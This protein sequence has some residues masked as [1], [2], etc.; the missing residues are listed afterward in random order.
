M[1]RKSAVKYSILSIF[2]LSLL[3]VLTYSSIVKAPSNGWIKEGN[4]VYVDDSNVYISAN[5]HTLHSSGWVYLNLTSKNYNGDI[6]IVFGFD[7]TQ[8]KPKKMLLYHPHDV[9]W[10]TT[11][12][13]TFY[14]VSNFVTT[15]DPCDYGHEY[16]SIKRDVT[17]TTPSYDNSTNTT[18]WNLVNS[19]VCFDSYEDLGNNNY[20]VTWHNE[21]S[22]IENWVDVSD[23]FN[24]I[25]YDFGGMNKW[26]YVTNVPVTAGENYLTKFYVQVPVS[27]TLS[28]GKYWIAVKPSS[29]TISEAISNEHLY[30]LDPWW[31]S[32]WSYRRN[33]TITENGGYDRTNYPFLMWVNDTKINNC[34][35]IRLVD[36]DGDE[37]PYFIAENLTNKCYLGTRVNVSASSSAIVSAYYGPTVSVDTTP[38]DDNY[39]IDITYN[40]DNAGQD[41]SD[42]REMWCNITLW[43]GTKYDSFKW[44]N[45]TDNGAEVYEL[46]YG[47]GEG[48]SYDHGSGI[49]WTRSDQD[50]K[51][52][53][54]TD[55]GDYHRITYKWNDGNGDND[56]GGTSDWSTMNIKSFNDVG[57]SIDFD[58]YSDVHGYVIENSTWYIWHDM[59]EPDKLVIYKPNT[60]INVTQEVTY[61]T[62]STYVDYLPVYSFGTYVLSYIDRDESV[63]TIRT[64]DQSNKWKSICDSGCDYNTGNTPDRTGTELDVSGCSYENGCAFTYDKV[65]NND[66]SDFY[67][68]ERSYSGLYDN[69]ILARRDTF[70]AWSFIYTLSSVNDVIN[71]RN[72]L[73]V[74]TGVIKT[75]ETFIW[76]TADTQSTL[77]DEY[78]VTS[79]RLTYSIGSEES[80][81]ANTPPT[82]LSNTSSVPS[83]YSPS[84]YSWF[85]ITWNDDN[86]ANGYNYSVIELN[87]ANYTTS[88][89][90][91]V[92][93]YKAILGAGTYTWKFYA[94]DSSNAWN[95]T[96]T[97]T[98]TIAKAD[99]PLTLSL[100]VTSPITYETSSKTTGSGCPAGVTCNLYRNTTGLVSNP[101]SVL[102]GAGSYQWVYN[103]SGNANYSS[104]STTIDLLVNKK[105]ANVQVFPITQTQTYPYTASQYCTDDA[106]LVSCSIY[107]NSVSITN[108]TSVQLSAGTYVYVANITDQTNYTGYTD[109]ET[110]TIN[111]APT[112]SVL[113]INGTNADKSFFRTDTANF[114]TYVNISGKTVGIDTNI[115]GWEAPTGVTPLYNYTIL[116][117]IGYFNITGYFAGDENYSMSYDTLYVT[118]SEAST[119]SITNIHW[120]TTGGFT[121]S[122]LNLNQILDSINC[123]ITDTSTNS[124]TLD[125]Y[126]PDGIKVVDGA[127]LT[128]T[129]SNYYYLNDI[130]LS[131]AG[132]WTINITASNNYHTGNNSAVI[133]VSTQSI[134]IKDG[135]YGYTDN[136]ILSSSRITTLSGYDYDLFEMK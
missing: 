13:M 59:K 32:S 120:I 133:T 109:T 113:L 33:I 2:I 19:V 35:E 64:Y 116:N 129:S 131:K 117:D 29:E 124:A 51:A 75:N 76:T 22:R 85:N 118:V 66:D 23:R 53:S 20:E 72:S 62:A 102:L 71:N 55:R 114:T 104:N 111:K 57:M 65:Y 105:V 115:T 10:N 77:Q 134:S 82:W 84:T 48:D 110:L 18:S 46:Y 8:V 68:V 108:D 119:P 60:I 67:Y 49:R 16:N 26:Y 36:E 107:R 79:N 121:T 28:S 93:Y 47:D 17:Y 37:L 96:D 123:T 27:L 99:S 40:W 92:S 31:N 101:D 125:V 87:G 100:N 69:W 90:G 3:F 126:D 56:G 25:N 74:T 5:P 38:Y 58:G 86:D 135:W 83:S 103:T 12:T 70:Q 50:Q 73:H 112:E 94:N 7:T 15:T 45:I 106:S 30:Y 61:S 42:T 34:G 88:R 80:Q 98:A 21:F 24:S 9:T 43:N 89:D 39:Q 41:R 132:T 91:N 14:N 54:V 78:N 128:N 136:N 11:S 81:S 63:H 122:S 52:N 6:D 95:S 1:D 130:T 97:W 127:S 4:R 44:I